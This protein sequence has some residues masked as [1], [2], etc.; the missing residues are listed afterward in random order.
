[1]F[2]YH[3]FSF[4][5]LGYLIPLLL[6]LVPF[7]FRQRI[8]VGFNIKDILIGVAVSAVVLLPFWLLASQA[9]RVFRLLSPRALSFQLLGVS[10]PEEIY[11]RG[12]LQ[13]SMGNNIKGVVMVSILFSVM[14]LPQYIFYGDIYSVLTFFPSLIMGYL[15][16]R[17]SNIVPST[18]F[19]FSSN[20]VF[21]GL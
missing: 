1:M 7:F 11:F 10:F 16:Y 3:A 5:F 13:E 19:H 14:H 17:T 6:I 21:L 18:I 8:N 2:V 4:S 12:F 9:G 15:Y 20:V